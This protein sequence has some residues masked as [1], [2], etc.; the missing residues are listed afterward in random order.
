MRTLALV[1]GEDVYTEP[2]PTPL[3][4][5]PPLKPKEVERRRGTYTAQAGTLVYVARAITGAVLYVGVT[6]NLFSRMAQHCQQSR[7]WDTM[8]TLSWEEWP[9]RESA[10][11]QETRL[12]VRYKPPF[13]VIH[14]P[15]RW[16]PM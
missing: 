8:D 9:D 7:W 15:D 5:P 2:D 16:R 1:L 11:R 3:P 13:N 12:I 4:P 6:D 10:L 14:N